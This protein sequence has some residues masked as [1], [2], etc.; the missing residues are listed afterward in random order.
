MVQDLE[1]KLCE[2]QLRSL[3][4]FSL[5]KRRHHCSYN[6]LV[7]RRGAGTDLLCGDQLWDLR[8]W[9]EVVSEQI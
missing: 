4:L 3:G 6:F 2:E 1:G 5:E 8:E 9:P 7:S